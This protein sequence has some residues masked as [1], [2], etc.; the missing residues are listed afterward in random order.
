[1]HSF[2]TLSYPVDLPHFNKF[3]AYSASAILMSLSNSST[4]HDMYSFVRM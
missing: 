4:V 3:I 1:M 2:E